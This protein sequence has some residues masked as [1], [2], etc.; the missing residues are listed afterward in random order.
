MTRERKGSGIRSAVAARAKSRRSPLRP[1][2]PIA[3]FAAAGAIALA[4][5]SAAAHG[6]VAPIASS[7]LARVSGAPP[8]V[9]AKV[10]D[11]DQ[12][13]WLQ[14]R[15]GLS[16]VVL[17]YRG[18]PYLRFSPGGV[19]VNQNSAMYYL[20][21]TPTLTPPAN[22]AP[23]TPPRWRRVSDGASY[24]WHDG[25][26]HALA[27]VALAPG[28]A[29]VGRW[30]I[31]L[32]VNGAPAGVSGGLWHAAHPSLVWFWPIIVLLGC[33][34]AGWRTR[35]PSLDR[36]LARGLGLTALL[37]FAA[38][39]LIR[40]LHGRPE[41]SVLQM[42]ELAAVLALA[43]Y[44]L[45]RLLLV[46]HG[47]FTYFVIAIIAL[48]Q[49]AELIPTLLQGFVLAAGPA[50][51]ARTAAILSLGTGIGLLV[52]V[53]RLADQGEGAPASERGRPELE[54]EDRRWEL[55]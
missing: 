55:A 53:F 31:P 28:A 44:C 41:V 15:R 39:V 3:L 2:F 36:Q 11:G 52:M 43:L 19:V 54:E 17:D 24:S 49:G 51:L 32:L 47:Y 27:S 37:A 5:A 42:I 6:P 38:A 30:R 34:L 1:S 8:G 10:V 26:L 23:S 7:Y 20:N 22:L 35:R 45:Y 48:W 12:R 29:F 21:Q 40:D 33:V 9:Q 18:S 50:F 4:P 14:V 46:R 25:R 13:M 16:V